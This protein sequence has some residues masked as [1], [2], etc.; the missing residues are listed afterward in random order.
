MQ[1]PFEESIEEATNPPDTR[2]QDNFNRLDPRKRRQRLLDTET[3]NGTYNEQWRTQRTPAR[4]HPLTKI[5]SQIAF[6][7]HLLHQQLAKSDEE[8]VNILQKHVDAVDNFVQRAEEDLDLAIADIRDRINYLKLPLEHKDVFDVMLDDKTFRM[9]ILEGNEK[10]EKVVDRTAA[11]VKDLQVDVQKGMESTIEMGKYLDD[12]SDDWP[13]NDHGSIEIFRTMQANVEGWVQCMSTLQMKG[14][15]LSVAVVQLGSVLSEMAK[16]AASASRREQVGIRS[17]L[18]KFMLIPIASGELN[19]HTAATADQGPPRNTDTHMAHRVTLSDEDPTSH[20]LEIQILLHGQLKQ[21]F[22]EPNFHDAIVHE[23]RRTTMRLMQCHR[24]VSLSLALLGLQNPPSQPSP[25][26]TRRSRRRSTL[27]RCQHL[28]RQILQ[29][30]RQRDPRS[31]NWQ[32]SSASMAQ[33]HHRLCPRR[34][35][36][37]LAFRPHRRSHHLPLRNC[38]LRLKSTGRQCQNR[39]LRR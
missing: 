28:R 27:T 3:T 17:L 10:I 6:G 18:T 39:N 5:I 9:Q 7:V 15:G 22:L 14:N 38:L 4:F 29:N 37:P 24:C 20:S 33:P 13:Q 1:G 19:E 32:A 2:A 31:L 11:L 30:L 26:V 12:I 35:Y 21:L 25:P 36:N 23:E 34:P 16:R 8:V